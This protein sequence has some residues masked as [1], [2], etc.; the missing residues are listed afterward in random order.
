MLLECDTRPRHEE[1]CK[2]YCWTGKWA[3]YGC[4]VCQGGDT[5]L[6][7]LSQLLGDIAVPFNCVPLLAGLLTEDLVKDYC[8]AHE[9]SRDSAS[10]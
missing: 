9:D 1:P 5:P 4:P 10:G 3:D 2:P 6:R 8:R 7:F